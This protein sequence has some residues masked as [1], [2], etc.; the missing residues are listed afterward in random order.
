MKHITRDDKLYRV[1]EKTFLGSWLLPDVINQQRTK[2]NFPIHGKTLASKPLQQPCPSFLETIPDVGPGVAQEG[3]RV[4][5]RASQTL[6]DLAIR[7]TD[8]S[9][10]SIPWP[11]WCSKMVV[12]ERTCVCTFNRFITLQDLAISQFNFVRLYASATLAW[13][14]APPN[15][16]R[17]SMLPLLSWRGLPLR[18]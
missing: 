5:G 15:Q 11:P 18:H 7:P 8:A 1:W 14:D 16:L 2:S 10:G 3:T 12:F 17:Y 13:L 4:Q 6:G 9:W